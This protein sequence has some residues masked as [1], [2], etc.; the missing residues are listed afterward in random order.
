MSNRIYLYPYLY[1]NKNIKNKAS[2]FETPCILIIN[3]V[4]SVEKTRHSNLKGFLMDS[5]GGG[6]MSSTS[7]KNVTSVILFI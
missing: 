1:P 4:E 7:I 2:I 6:S 3:P 5:R